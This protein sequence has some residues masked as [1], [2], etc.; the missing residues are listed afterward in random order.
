VWGNVVVESWKRRKE[1]EE[2]G[3]VGRRGFWE[4]H[5]LH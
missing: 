4:S 5:S 3:S 1:K 2:G